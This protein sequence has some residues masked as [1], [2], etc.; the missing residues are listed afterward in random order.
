MAGS[1]VHFEDLEDH[2]AMHALAW[3]YGNLK[4]FQ[5]DWVFQ[6]CPIDR[7]RN[8]EHDDVAELCGGKSGT[9]IPLVRRG[10]RCGPNFDLAAGY[11]LREDEDI[12]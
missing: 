7:H 4:Q 12:G 11:D 1:E 10:L 3:Q 5:V 2:G 9:V 6:S 8:K